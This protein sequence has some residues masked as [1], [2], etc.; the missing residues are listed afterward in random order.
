MSEALEIG[1]LNN[2]ARDT[3]AHMQPGKC[4]A[5]PPIHRRPEAR[6]NHNAQVRPWG[7]VEP[8][9]P[10]GSHPWS[11][12]RS[13][14]QRGAASLRVIAALLGAVGILDSPWQGRVSASERSSPS[15]CAFT[16]QTAVVLFTRNRQTFLPESFSNQ[17]SLHLVRCTLRTAHR[18]SSQEVCGFAMETKHPPGALISII[19]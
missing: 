13:Q 18:G 2:V 12:A 19:G 14:T 6:G 8:T 11:E 4:R 15:R 3:K 5:P 9:W 16:S 10:S 17:V 1:P 7:R